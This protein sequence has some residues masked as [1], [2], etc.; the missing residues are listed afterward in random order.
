[1]ANLPH[2]FI[3]IPI[4]EQQQLWISNMPGQMKGNGY[5]SVYKTWP[6]H[7]DLHITLK[8]LGPV[9]Q[10]NIEQLI[11]DLCQLNDKR[12]NLEIGGLGYFGNLTKPRV[13]WMGVEQHSSLSELHGQV[14]EIC[15]LSGFQKETRSYRP[16]I[17]LAKK[18]GGTSMSSERWSAL[19]TMYSEQHTFT[20]NRLAVYQIHPG[21][22]PKYE[23]IHEVTL[24]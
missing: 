21:Q 14:E 18:W 15:H 16:H 19:R 23:I 20:V 9:K 22:S 13:L 12:F 5:G 17:T 3:G 8:F 1:M 10:Q 11:A 24:K 7:E 2:Y 6:H 4:P